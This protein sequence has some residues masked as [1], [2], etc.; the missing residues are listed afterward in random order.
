MIDWVNAVIWYPHQQPIHGGHADYSDREGVH[1]GSVRRK[2]LA[3]GSWDSTCGIQTSACHPGQDHLWLSASPKFVQGHNLFGT[4]DLCLL[5]ERIAEA[6]LAEVGHTLDYFSRRKIQLGEFDVTLVD[7]TEMLDCGNELNARSFMNVAADHARMKHRGRGIDD[8]GTLYWGKHSDYSAH[9]LYLK[10]QEIEGK[11]K[12]HRLPDDFPWR[13]QLVDYAR[14]CA[15]FETRLYSKALKDMRLHR[16]EYWKG[17]DVAGLRRMYMEQLSLCANI[18]M[19]DDQVALL[20]AKLRGTYALWKQGADM[21]QVLSKRTF[22]RHR[23]ELM[24]HGIDIST[25]VGSPENRVVSLRRVIEARP[26]GIPE[27]ALGTPLVVAA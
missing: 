2:H 8:R 10:L 5:V 26:K 15:R 17:F 19:T 25:P 18:E 6:A 16:G 22:F 23:K 9:K 20:P 4:D 27:W 12:E 14:G 24:V 21:T 7:I 11:S 3:R 13:Q 1:T